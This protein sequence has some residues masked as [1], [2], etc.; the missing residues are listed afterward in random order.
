MS[1]DESGRLDKEFDED[2]SVIINGE[3][4]VSNGDVSTEEGNILKKNEKRKFD[5]ECYD[6]R[7]FYSML[8]K[9]K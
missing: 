7:P 8:L 2:G 6:D 9:V 1:W 3:N 5:S 4:R